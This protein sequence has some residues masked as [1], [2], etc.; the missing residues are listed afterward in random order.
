[1]DNVDALRELPDIRQIAGERK[2]RWFSSPEL[3]LILWLGDDDA[4]VGFQLCYDKHRDERALTWREDRG[5]DHAGVDDGE[6]TPAQHKSTPIL[7]ADGHFD[8]DRVKTR[9]LESSANVP[10]PIRAFVARILD[11]YP[12]V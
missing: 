3:D 10:Q 1:M 5:F 2:R 11:R 6:H 4:P 8:R 12:N 9:F 7:V